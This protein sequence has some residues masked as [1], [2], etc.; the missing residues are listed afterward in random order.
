MARTAVNVVGNSLA[1]AVIDKSEEKAAAKA[2]D[3]ATT[4]HG[5]DPVQST[6]EA[7][8]QSNSRQPV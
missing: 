2:A 4:E 6:V 5:A 1:A 7:D 3:R 8:P